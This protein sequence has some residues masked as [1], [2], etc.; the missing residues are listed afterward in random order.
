MSDAAATRL[1]RRLALDVSL[2]VIRAL[3]VFVPRLDRADWVEEW[4]SELCARYTNPDSNSSPAPTNA[5]PPRFGRPFEPLRDARGA[6]PD[7]LWHARE[8]WRLD[9]LSHDVRFAI[10]TLLARPAFTLT[11]VVTLALGIGANAVI[12]SAVDAVVLNPFDFEEPDRITGVGTIY[13]RL[14]VDLGFFERLSAPEVADIERE[15]TAFEA[16]AAFDMGNRQIIG[17]DVPQNLFSG[18]WWHDVLPVLGFEPVL[19]RG[20]SRQDIVQGERVA[21]ISNRV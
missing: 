13:P 12:F 18:F 11:V 6:I 7:A 9:M 8:D 14:N 17:G 21:L 4:Q 3:S 10:R 15:V 20:F 16:V 1:A 2:A 19:G 5:P